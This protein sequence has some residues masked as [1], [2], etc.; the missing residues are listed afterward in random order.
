MENSEISCGL[1]ILQTLSGFNGA[2]LYHKSNK[3]IW[4]KLDFIDCKS[5]EP[6]YYSYCSDTYIPGITFWKSSTGL[7]G[8]RR[9]KSDGAITIILP[10]FIG[11]H[12][13]NVWYGRYY[14]NVLLVDRD[15]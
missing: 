7:R 9:S 15:L 13:A 8:K 2:E 3:T 6:V 1:V 5:V 10:E 4:V 14:W 11:Y 12:I